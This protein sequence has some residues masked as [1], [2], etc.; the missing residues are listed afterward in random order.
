MSDEGGGYR[1]E[2][3][4]SAV[5]FCVVKDVWGQMGWL[6]ASLRRSH[7]MSEG[8]KKFCQGVVG[9]VVVVARLGS[10]RGRRWLVG[11]VSFPGG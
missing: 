8:L 1:W 6:L 5:V 2:C 4:P 10:G 7:I 3:F 11:L 9:Q